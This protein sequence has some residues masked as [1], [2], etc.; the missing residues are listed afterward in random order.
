MSHSPQTNPNVTDQ[1]PQD[2]PVAP[3]DFMIGN[4]VAVTL[5][6][7]F[8]F[9]AGILFL[10][11]SVRK[12]IFP[13]SNSSI[14]NVSIVLPQASPS[15]VESSILLA[16]EQAVRDVNGVDR[17]D[18][19]AYFGYARV[20]I[21]LLD[22]ADAQETLQAVESRI[23]S[24]TSFPESAE[25]PHIELLNNFKQV[26]LSFIVFGQKTVEELYGFAGVM[27][28]RLLDT[29]D[30][31]YAKID[32]AKKYEIRVLLQSH[33]LQQHALS[34]RE[35]ANAIRAQSVE[36][37]A[38]SVQTPAQEIALKVNTKARALEDMRQLV[39]RSGPHYNLTLN[40]I[41][42]FEMGF[43]A[44][45][46]ATYFN[47]KPAVR[48]SVY[49]I[50]QENPVD[51]ANRAKAFIEQQQATL[52]EGI[53]MQLF[54]DRS[55]FFAERLDL[56]MRNAA[57]GIL[58]IFLVIGLFL[59]PKLAFW[60]MLGMPISIVGA[61]ILFAMF[62]VSIN[63]ITMFAFIVTLGIVVDDA[64]IVGEQIY[65]MREMGAPPLLAAKLGVKRMLQPV[66]FAVVTNIVSF[67]P[68]FFLPGDWHTP[69]MQI[70]A[71]VVAVLLV[72]LVEC[73]FILPA[74]LGHSKKS[75]N[76]GKFMRTISFPQ[77]YCNSKLNTWS[78]TS[79][80]SFSSFVLRKR[81]IFLLVGVLFV[82]LSVIVP[83][84][85]GLVHFSFFPSLNSSSVRINIDMPDNAFLGDSE[86]IVKRIVAAQ[87]A[88]EKALDSEQPI[89]SG[90]YVNIK[91]NKDITITARLNAYGRQ[92]VGGQAFANEWR[93]Q[94]GD[95]RGIESLKI[96]ST[97]TPGP[98]GGNRADINIEVATADND[99]AHAF[100]AELVNYLNATAGVRD[101]QD[102]F[103]SGKTEVQMVASE[104]AEYL[105]ISQ[106]DIAQVV[107]DAISGVDVQSF[108]QGKDEVTIKTRLDTNEINTSDALNH[109]F[110]KDAN[111]NYIPVSSL[112]ETQTTTLVPFIERKDSRRVYTI[113]ANVDTS[114][115]RVATVKEQIKQQLLP[116]IRQEHPD[117]RVSL[118]AMD[119]EIDKVVEKL[120]LYFFISGFVIYALLAVLFRSYIQ[121]I[122]IMISIPF[123]VGG[124]MIGHAILGIDFSLFSA[125]GVVA[126]SGVVINTG[127]LLIDSMN[128]SRV[129]GMTLKD[130]SVTAIVRRFRPIII[131]TVTT[132]FGVMP[133]V[134]ETSQQAQF[135]IPMAVSLSFGIAF[136]AA[137]TLFLMPSMELALQDS[138]RLLDRITQVLTR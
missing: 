16:V 100:S 138:R 45:K 90:T 12:E 33:L 19:F 27:R 50:G 115:V 78:Q 105:G 129:S 125:I 70:P 62:D 57:L 28:D 112:V 84:A 56:M 75:N 40:D 82:A 54:S 71:T 116:K 102:G 43:D 34:V 21:Y 136:S 123:G 46:G 77:R 120:K 109:I 98:E 81:Y 35:V 137:I 2:K 4:P 103:P 118:D 63:M 8:I 74:H 49:S 110:F 130:A 36:V 42:R 15:E 41:A 67:M 95:L 61:F 101:V 26:A 48:V 107:R 87:A 64:V 126:L 24:I 73:L 31:A 85:T 58:L 23:N 5:L 89:A 88:T 3:L 79:L 32:D 117:A 39:I 83:V 119:T 20:A 132:F 72:S 59:E 99:V 80:R 97:F 128:E 22:E 25:T 65:K 38:G 17:I 133:I 30:V 135:L 7:L 51:V 18:S 108:Y 94:I 29:G 96:I 44:Q 111:G 52:P 104:R 93:T 114:I 113:R 124:A 121:P 91:D 66:T 122:A 6:M 14:I 92:V 47:G 106:R 131:T 1:L 60:V 127:L 9:V 69:F 10:N 37:S 55:R 13:S 86:R 76:E 53:S 134:F 11:N 68:M